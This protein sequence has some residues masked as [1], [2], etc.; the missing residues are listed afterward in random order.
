M[1]GV[2]S[3]SFTLCHA[4]VCARPL[5]PIISPHNNKNNKVIFKGESQ[6]D[7]LLV[8]HTA[9]GKGAGLTSPPFAAGRSH[10]WESVVTLS[11]GVGSY[12][13]LHLGRKHGRLRTPASLV[14]SCLP[15]SALP[16]QLPSGAHL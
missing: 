14:H 2:Q 12:D 15:P 1:A 11:L 8:P 6:P 9:V 3:T 4:G 10:D 7:P 13:E 16:P 5:P